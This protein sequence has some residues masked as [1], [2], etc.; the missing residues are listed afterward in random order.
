[1]RILFS[2][3]P[4]FG[5]LLPML[6]LAQAAQQAGHQ[7]AFLTNAVMAGPL[8]PFEVLSAGPDVGPMIGEVARRSGHTDPATQTMPALTAELPQQAARLAGHGT[9]PTGPL[10]NAELFAGTRVDLSIDEA[11][12]AARRFAPD[13]I[14]AE[15]ADF[16]G[17][18]VSAVLEVPWV[19]HGI[20]L[21]GLMGGVVGEAMQARV[22]PQYQAHHLTPTP[23]LAVLDVFPEQ[24]QLPGWTPEPG[25]LTLQPQPYS[26]GDMSWTAPAFAG[27]EHLPTVLMTL[28]TL[29]DDPAVPAGLIG[30][31]NA[32]EVNVIVTVGSQEKA[33]AFK[34]DR[35]RVLPV[36]FVPISRLLKAAD[37]VVS[38]GGAGTVLAALSRSLPLVILP[39]VADQPV[40]AAQVAAAGAGV[41][42]SSPAELGVAVSTI[43]AD[44]SYRAAAQQ[45]GEQIAQM[46]SPEQ[47]L[48]LLSQRFEE[49]NTGHRAAED[50]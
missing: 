29:I 39:F 43:L 50:T 25:T 7:V 36:G 8:Q 9:P 24:L 18:L 21:G 49:S 5:H 47:V 40:N 12:P 14:V 1:M 6:P 33:D 44:P 20:I 41:V 17:P 4:A 16:V 34:A 48:A 3:V 10:L 26:L 46:H 45:L 38:A 30:T 2:G 19:K 32:A 27:R 28:G 11:L 35:S 13:L 42:V 31:L 23:P 37:L 15:D 22:A